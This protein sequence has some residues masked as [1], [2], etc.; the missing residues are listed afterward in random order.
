MTSSL[1]N[2]ESGNTLDDPVNGRSETV[3]GGIVD[4]PATIDQA[5]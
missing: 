2:A 1:I 5:G 3:T 4:L